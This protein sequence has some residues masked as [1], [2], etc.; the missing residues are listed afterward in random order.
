MSESSQLAEPMK[1][2]QMDEAK[3]E[4][5]QPQQ[6]QQQE[7]QSQQQPDDGTPAQTSPA[8]QPS[9]TH[10]LGSAGPFGL[11]A[12]LDPAVYAHLLHA[13]MMQA[14]AASTASLLPAQRSAGR[15]LAGSGGSSVSLLRGPLSLRERVEQTNLAA[16]H[17]ALRR[18]A[19]AVQSRPAAGAHGHGAAA[20]GRGECDASLYAQ[21]QANH[22]ATV[23]RQANMKAAEIARRNA[24]MV[25]KITRTVLQ[26]PGPYGQ[27]VVNS[28]S[29]VGSTTPYRGSKHDRP[30]VHRSL[31]LARRR[32]EQARIAQE[33]LVLAR[34]I[35]ERK[36]RVAAP[37][38]WDTHASTHGAIRKNISRYIEVPQPAAQAHAYQPGLVPTPQAYAAAAAAAA[39]GGVVAPLAL[40]P[41]Y[42]GMD[43]FTQ[44]QQQQQLY[45][46]H[47]QLQAQAQV[48]MQAQA[49]A[50]GQGQGFAPGVFHPSP[51]SY[52]RGSTPTSAAGASSSAGGGGGPLAPLPDA[53]KRSARLH[54]K[55]IAAEKEKFA[56]S[57][58]SQLGAPAM[59]RA[60]RA[61]AYA[62]GQV[63]ESAENCALISC[64]CFFVPPWLFSLFLH[65][66][67]D[68]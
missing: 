36:P 4:E 15:S 23:A 68:S 48:Q 62:A 66:T 18:A 31:N 2:T 25:G 32:A 37:G 58:A 54:R 5:Q 16:H 46:H 20:A 12:P 55:M 38:E 47:M 30:F 7:Q 21:V 49:Q 57:P 42:G 29:G 64:D 45:F 44:Q 10:V 27:A 65:R 11:A 13:Q 43:A 22:A 26:A 19:P 52:P 8:T 51:P 14:Q 35:I 60:A 6:Q 34:R 39:T 40:P 17:A 63:F 67:F 33:N 9:D 41:G 61:H 28:N 3:E 56:P 53:Q 50:M 1:R 59:L 24:A